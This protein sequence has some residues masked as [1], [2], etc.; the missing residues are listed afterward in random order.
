MLSEYVHAHQLSENLMVGVNK[1]NFWNF[2]VTISCTSGQ[3]L[4]NDADAS[5][6]SAGFGAIFKHL[7]R[8][9]TKFCIFKDFSSALEIDF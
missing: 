5:F 6:L 3:L 8:S 9:F 7:S 1:G 4:P 2:K